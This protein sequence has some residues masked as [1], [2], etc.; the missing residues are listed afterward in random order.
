[1]LSGTKTYELKAKLEFK[2]LHKG[3]MFLVLYVGFS[4]FNYKY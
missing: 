2:N 1:M 4:V 3:V